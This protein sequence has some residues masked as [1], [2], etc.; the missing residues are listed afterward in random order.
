MYYFIVN[1]G[2]G[3]GRGKKTLKNVTGIL[4]AEMIPY[5]AWRT[6]YPGHATKLTTSIIKKYGK[7]EG[8][9]CI[10]VVGGDGT[11]NEVLNGI[12]DFEHV[13]LG[14][15]PTGSGNDFV[16]G[17]G[18]PKKTVPALFQILNCE[19]AERTDLGWVAGDSNAPRIFGISAGIG[20]DAEVCK[21]AL[22]SKQ[23]KLLNGLGVGK[24]TYLLLT[25]ESLIT[26]K[27]AG[28]RVIF[29]G[30]M[31][32]VLHMKRL[33]FLAGMN[34]PWEGGGV[35]MSPDASPVDGRLST[36]VADGI[37]KW[38]TFFELPVLVAGKHKKLKEI[39]K[40][41]LQLMKGGRDCACGGFQKAVSKMERD[42]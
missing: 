21:K 25:V 5:H 17:H 37:A 35:P 42:D 34:T 24:L 2:G 20:L 13:W 33:I 28:G 14:V 1:Y 23:K 22:K 29:D 8:P 27:T 38:K 16:R 39:L 12:T 19:L 4:D 31:E 26:M 40:G 6:E 41:K 18:L 9:I 7:K 3:R 30:D 10:V 32:N 15:I 36:C 11:I